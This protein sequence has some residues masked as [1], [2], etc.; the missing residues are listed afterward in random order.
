MYELPYGN[1][2]QLNLDWFIQRWKEFYEEWEQT[3]TEIDGALDE[4]VQKVEDAMEDLYAARDAAAASATAAAASATSASNDATIAANA[5]TAAAASATLANTKATAAGLSEAAAALSASQAANDATA[6]ATSASQASASASSATDSAQAAA[7]SEQNIESIIEDAIQDATDAAVAEATA[8]AEAAATAAESSASDAADSATAAAAS[9]TA[10]DSSADDA[11]DSATAAAGS[12]TA[13]A[14]SASDAADSATAAAASAASIVVDSAMSDSSTNPVQNKVING[15][16]TELK[17]ALNDIRKPYGNL[18]YT[19]TWFNYSA[20]I[21]FSGDNIIVTATSAGTYRVTSCKIDTSDIDYLTVSWASK[22]PTSPSTAASI[23]WG[24]VVSGTRTWIG[25]ITSSG[26]VLDVTEINEIEFALY[27]DQASVAKGDQATFTKLQLEVGVSATAF[28]KGYTTNDLEADARLD[29]IEPEVAD[30]IETSNLLHVYPW[31]SNNT[32][33]VTF[34]GDNLVLTAT[35]SGTYRNA[36]WDIDV[37][38]ADYI[39]ISWESISPNA[40][41]KVRIGYIVGATNTWIKYVNAPEAI[42]VS[43]YNKVRIGLY[44]NTSTSVDEDYAVTYTKLMVEAGNTATGFTDSGYSAVDYV[45]RNVIEELRPEGNLRYFGKRI[46]VS[47][48]PTYKTKYS[49]WKDFK[50]SEISGLADYEL[51]RGQ[52]IAIFGGVLFIFLASVGKCITMDFATKTITGEWDISGDGHANSAQFTDMYYDADDDYPILMISKCSDQSGQS[53]AN[54]AAL[55]YRVQYSES[56]FT[57]TLLSKCVLS[58]ITY[59]STWALDNNSKALYCS[60]YKNGNYSV[61]DNNPTYI[62]VFKCPTT[63]TIIAG[64]DTTFTESDAETI[65]ETGH[66][67]MQGCF[68]HNGLLY[69]GNSDYLYGHSQSLW[70]YNVYSRSIISIVDFASSK[71]AEGLCLYNGKLYVQQRTGSSESDNPMIITEYSFN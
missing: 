50:S 11:A 32:A 39:N 63:A 28:N 40:S 54:D 51:W 53:Y 46:N 34:S 23:R 17:T 38:D 47:L 56:T 58:Q 2:Q 5:A 19:A 61:S 22:T 3:K 7:T 67:I 25:Y 70:V 52:S 4:E 43:T 66:I 27:V 16:L 35:S 68:G 30:S 44:C 49:V 55:F 48:E 37:S 59:G 62:A 45:A 29:K 60:Y 9:A 13:A 18:L 14:G 71:E 41:D 36:Y 6:A 65:F 10:A 31:A 64:T 8:D 26:T 24:K 42:D 20:A 21:S 15:E 57:F 69:V 1:T 33:E 12:A